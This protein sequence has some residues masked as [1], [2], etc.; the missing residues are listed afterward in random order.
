MELELL[1]KA[2]GDMDE[3]F[4]QEA[5]RLVLEDALNA[6]EIIIQT[7]NDHDHACIG[8]DCREENHS[9]MVAMQDVIL[10]N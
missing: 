6:S 3:C 5:Y 9:S 2:F 1:S 7:R 10:N 8:P 4:V